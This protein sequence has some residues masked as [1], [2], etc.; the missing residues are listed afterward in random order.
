MN[1]P[2]IMTRDNDGVSSTIATLSTPPETA[3]VSAFSPAEVRT[4]LGLDSDP[5]VYFSVMPP[6]TSSGAASL[7]TTATIGSW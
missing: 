1:V 6:I 3:S 5:T 7:P 4:A 2:M